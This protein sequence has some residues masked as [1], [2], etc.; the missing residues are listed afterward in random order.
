ML[1]A[2]NTNCKPP[3]FPL[4]VEKVGLSST[5]T[6]PNVGANTPV[7]ERPWPVL[8]WTQ[9]A[10]RTS[11][12]TSTCRLNA[13][14]GQV[15]AKVRSGF[16]NYLVLTLNRAIAKPDSDHSLDM[17]WGFPVEGRYTAE[18]LKKVLSDPN[19]CVNP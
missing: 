13:E 1:S 12:S 6:L 2:A 9:S 3:S 10:Q 18:T 14:W 19:G 15:P 16:G 4:S 5:G 7:P 11:C 8:P 17:P